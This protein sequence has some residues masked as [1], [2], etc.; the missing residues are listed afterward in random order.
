MLFK[1]EDIEVPVLSVGSSDSANSAFCINAESYEFEKVFP[2]IEKGKD[3]HFVSAGSWSNIALLEFLLNFTG[4]SFLYITS[5][6]ISDYAIKRLIAL[7]EKNMITGAKCIFDKRTET[8]NPNILDFAQSNIDVQLTSIHAKNMV[9]IGEHFNLCVV[10]S[11]NLNENKRIESGVIS[12]HD[13]TVSFHKNWINILH[14][15]L[16]NGAVR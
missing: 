16:K 6:S 7:K 14:E 1:F 9:I 3:Y 13:N 11:S 5:W 8:F 10:Q 12:T 2:T 15:S 4:K